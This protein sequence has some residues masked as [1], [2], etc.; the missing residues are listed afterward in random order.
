MK[1]LA[2]PVI[3]DVGGEGHFIRKKNPQKLRKRDQQANYDGASTSLSLHRDHR[4]PGGDVTGFR[5]IFEKR[6]RSKRRRVR[7]LPTG[8]M[9]ASRRPWAHDHPAVGR[10]RS[11]AS[12]ST[13]YA[14]PEE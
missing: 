7:F 3:S 13:V 6:Q 10:G 8:Q 12:P 1:H 5:R 2:V 14:L 11:K 4:C 9:L